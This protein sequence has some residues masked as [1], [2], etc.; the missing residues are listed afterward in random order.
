ME[1]SNKRLQRIPKSH[2]PP[3]FLHQR[4]P[5]PPK[6]PSQKQTSSPPGHRPFSGIADLSGNNF[7]PCVETVCFVVVLHGPQAMLNAN[8]PLQ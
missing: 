5:Q 6:P 4:K 8:L 2:T 1:P 3:A 7:C